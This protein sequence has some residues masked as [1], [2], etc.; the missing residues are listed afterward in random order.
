MAEFKTPKK[1]RTPEK[2][3]P[4]IR[5]PPSPYLQELGYGCGMSLFIYCERY[6]KRNNL[7]QI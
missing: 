4:P 5:I 6:L 1:F 2:A 3:L 7:K